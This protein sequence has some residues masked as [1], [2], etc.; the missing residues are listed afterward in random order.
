MLW[1]GL[2]F[3]LRFW[4]VRYFQCPDLQYSRDKQR[5]W[6]Q[7]WD[8][9]T[10]LHAEVRSTEYHHPCVDVRVHH[11]IPESLLHP[12]SCT[13]M[14]VSS[15]GLL[16]QSATRGSLNNRTLFF[17]SY[18]G[19]ECGLQQAG[20]L[21]CLREHVSQTSSSEVMAGGIQWR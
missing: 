11:P 13:N 6:V 8:P 2:L 14:H 17:P 15:L 12:T 5:I 4:D 7:A 18:R 3:L 21:L 9:L 20:V 19:Q 1:F 16:G 10:D